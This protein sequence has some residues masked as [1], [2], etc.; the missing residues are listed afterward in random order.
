M[1]ELLTGTAPGGASGT[2]ESTPDGLAFIPSSS[3]T[4]WAVVEPDVDP[5]VSGSFTINWYG[6][7]RANTS[8]VLIQSFGSYGWL[9][10]SSAW[11]P[12]TIRLFLGSYW[13]GG[14][15]NS[16]AVSVTD[17]TYHSVS[18]V[19]NSTTGNATFY[20][21]GVSIH[22]SAFTKDPG[23][24]GPSQQFSTKGDG[25]LPHK[26]ITAQVYTGALSAGDITALAADPFIIFSDGSSPP[27]ETYG[28]LNVSG[29][30]KTLSGL[31]ANVGGTR[32]SGQL[33]SK[34]SGVWKPLS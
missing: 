19:F 31:Y 24:M 21:D 15:V 34:V 22:S 26:C 3:A 9:F 30:W 28:S 32:K 16:I 18:M 2:T 5:Y 13:G 12:G 17:N 8:Q 11:S 20:L 4:T 6:V 33:Y 7:I 23:A 27:A 29:S 14:G 10:T 25:S 1:N